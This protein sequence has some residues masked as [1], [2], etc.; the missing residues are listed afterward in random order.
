MKKM[1]SFA[2]VC[3]IA[4]LASTA[5]Q[6]DTAAPQ[7]NISR[8]KLAGTYKV[9]AMKLKGATGIEADLFTTLP[10]CQKAG[11]QTLSPNSSYLLEDACNP[12]DNQ[13][14]SWSY[15]SA[16]QIVING[17]AGGIVSF[18]GTNLVLSFDNFLGMSG[19]LTETLTKQ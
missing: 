15:V 10:D 19:T 13:T 18:D 9:T 7:P 8:E 6:K 11:R 12:A 2:L 1:K 17:M 4:A 5:C 14:G 3:V 16:Q